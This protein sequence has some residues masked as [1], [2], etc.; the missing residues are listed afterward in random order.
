MPDL[1]CCVESHRY[2]AWKGAVGAG[3]SFCSVPHE[4]YTCPGQFLPATQ[5]A[6]QP[7][8]SGQHADAA[9]RYHTRVLHQLHSG[10][11]NVPLAHTFLGFHEQKEST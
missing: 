4:K 3:S 5:T 1:S 6:L 11:V 2:L 9:S 10:C 8:H 7:M